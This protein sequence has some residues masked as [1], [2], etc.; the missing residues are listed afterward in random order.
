MGCAGVAGTG[1]RAMEADGPVVVVVVC[2]PAENELWASVRKCGYVVCAV[3][4]VRGRAPTQVRRRRRRLLW[5]V[6]G[7][8]RLGRTARKVREMRQNGSA[9]EGVDGVCVGMSVS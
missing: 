2:C 1:R 6:T 9:E 8:W 5:D 3:C 7:H 4:G